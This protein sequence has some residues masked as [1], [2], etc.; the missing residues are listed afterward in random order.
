MVGSTGYLSL[1]SR[2]D[3]DG[4]L[5]VWRINQRCLLLPQPRE[6]L[7]SCQV[8]YL[9]VYSVIGLGLGSAT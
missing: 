2:P 8:H 3:P 9:V 1:V 4:R 5:E 6:A 7:D